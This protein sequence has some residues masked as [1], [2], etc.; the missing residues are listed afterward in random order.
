MD[1]Q[2]LL[3]RIKELE[4]RILLYEQNGSA[5]LYY[6]LE[7]KMNE[8]A[9]LMNKTNL[10]TLDIDDPKSKSFDRLKVI[11]N[12][13]SS[14]AIAVKALGEAAGISGDEEKDV[15]PRI[16]ITSPESIA[17]NIGELAGQR[18]S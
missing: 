15:K 10:E 11:W 1:E 14:I 17:D 8:M 13:A 16:R 3:E 9:N 12:D 2:R 4:S 5:K 7:R 18:Y 6:A